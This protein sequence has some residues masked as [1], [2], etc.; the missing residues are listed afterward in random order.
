MEPED[1]V[2]VNPVAQIVDLDLALEEYRQRWREYRIENVYIRG[3]RKAPYFPWKEKE[4]E[5]EIDEKY[6]N[7]FI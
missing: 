2:R 4:D 7:L 5:R 3:L 6:E 1:E